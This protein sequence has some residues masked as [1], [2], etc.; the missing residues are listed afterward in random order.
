[1]TDYPAAHSMDTTWFAV[2]KAGFVAEFSTGEAG[3]IPFDAP[4]PEGEDDVST[5]LSRILPRVG[6]KHDLI[7]NQMPPFTVAEHDLVD[8]DD[9]D[10]PQLLFL[11]NLEAVKDELASGQAIEVPA[12]EGHAVIVRETSIS[13][14]EQIHKSGACLGCF[15]YFGNLL[16]EEEASEWREL[17]EHGLYG[18]THLGGNVIANP[19]G[20]ETVPITPVHL[21][22]LPSDLRRQIRW[23]EFED[24]LF[25]ES[26][27]I[28]PIEHFECVAWGPA[29]LTV[30]GKKIAP[31]PGEEDAYAIEYED[32][33][34]TINDCE[35]VS[36]EQD[37]EGEDADD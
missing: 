35:V 21:D 14:S 8:D 5:E 12:V 32:F 33:L 34:K 18:Y 31:I 4:A 25:S 27:H 29:Y 3:A 19:Y 16:D 11:T 15:W 13:F 1:M 26:T 30:D 10:T 22:Q 9:D 37:E 24:L 20:R 36:P 28:Q 7:G 6:V 23:V 17:A 2:D